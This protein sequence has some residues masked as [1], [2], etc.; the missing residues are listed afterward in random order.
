MK[1]KITVIGLML[2][3]SA[4]TFGQKILQNHEKLS[5]ASIEKC[6]KAYNGEIEKSKTTYPLINNNYSSESTFL[7]SAQS[8]K[9]KLDSLVYSD[10]DVDA[11][12]WTGSYKGIYTYDDN[13]NMTQFIYRSWNQDQNLWID[14]FKGDFSFDAN[15]NITLEVDYHFIESSNEWVKSMKTAY[16]YDENGYLVAYNEYEWNIENNQWIISHRTDFTYDTNEKII[17]ELN[18]FWNE[19][20]NQ[21]IPG[22]KKENTYDDN[23]RITTE[24]WF[25]Y[26]HEE[27]NPDNG[28]FIESMKQEYTYD[29]NGY[30][31]QIL[32]FTYDFNSSIWM[33][34]FQEIYSYDVNGNMNR[35]INSDW[36]DNNSQ[37]LESNK[38]EY[39]YN[40][41]Y[42]YANLILPYYNDDE[43]RLIFNH[44]LMEFIEYEKDSESWIPV[45]NGV[46]YY[47]E[48]N[49]TNLNITERKAIEI[50]PNPVSDVLSIN[51]T[52]S[53]VVSFEMF[54][55]HGRKVM[56]K[57]VKNNEQ[58]KLDGLNS[59]MY[60]YNLFI[61]GKKLS[62]KLIKE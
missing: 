51:F 60:L 20:Y 44:M 25:S 3:I 19:D 40:N 13:E 48:K 47:S 49:E 1:Q 12:Q 18:S 21:W 24:L 14:F 7:K 37:W 41:A 30:M 45:Q 6:W 38:G 9:Q 46:F 8:T 4:F 50:F 29:A 36:D 17:Q 53:N 39:S 33:A 57:D 10:W 23:L 58:V 28:Q 2:L 52:E 22:E 32:F 54:D 27:G 34:S 55:I 15:G 42:T 56:A 5:R 62:G 11:S 35:I 16:E 59:G 26:V 31:T 43:T 61:D